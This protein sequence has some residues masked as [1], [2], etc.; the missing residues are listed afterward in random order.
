MLFRS[1]FTGESRTR[2]TFEQNAKKENLNIQTA[3]EIKPLDAVISGVDGNAREIVRWIFTEASKNE[4]AE[5]PFTAGSSF[6]V[7]LVTDLY[8]EGTLSVERARPSCEFKIRQKKKTEQA[9]EKAAKVNSLNELARLFNTTPSRADSVTLGNPQIPNIGFEPRV[10]GMA[11]HKKTQSKP[12]SAIEG[13]SGVFFIQTEK[14]T[15]L[16]NPNLDVTGQQRVQ[17]QQLRMFAQR[18][19]FD[20]LKKAAKI[21][22]NRFKFF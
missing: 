15:A 10:V 8:D 21:T 22:D 13:E 9:A 11:F 17:I 2:K 5:R 4:I 7:P 20:N 3:I 16:P 18:G 1:Q 19:L 14:L 6:V 12:S